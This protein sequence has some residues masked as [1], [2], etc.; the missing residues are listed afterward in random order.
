MIGEPRPVGGQNLFFDLRGE[1]WLFSSGTVYQIEN[2]SLIPV[3]GLV[4]LAA[5]K[6]ASGEIW[7]VAQSTGPPTLW[8][9][10][11]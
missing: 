6:S 7:L 8:K 2:Q 3:E 1:P 9:L 10:E 4:V 11:S 5:A